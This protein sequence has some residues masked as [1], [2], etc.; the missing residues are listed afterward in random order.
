MAGGCRA[1]GLDEIGHPIEGD[2]FEAFARLNAEGNGKVGFARAGF[3]IQKEVV[4]VVDEDALGEIVHGHRGRGL[5]FVEIEIGERF[6]FWE[7]CGLD[8]A[9]DGHRVPSVNFA[10]EQFNEEIPLLALFT[11]NGLDKRI[12]Q[13][14]PFAP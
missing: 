6:E 2:F 9:L 11:L 8:I 7:V 12:A 10:F 4:A 5:N 14:Q 3:A 1:Q 13:P